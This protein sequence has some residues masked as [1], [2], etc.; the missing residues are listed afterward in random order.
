MKEKYIKLNQAPF[1]NKSVRKAIM[2][3]TQLL[4]KFRKEN[5]FINELAY[6]RQRNFCTTLIKKT[7]RNFYNNLNVNKITDNKS[8]W[9]TVKPSFTEKTL[10]D[11]KIVLVE[12]DTT[13]SEE[14]EVAEIFRSYFDGIVDGL[15]I[16]RCEISKEDSDP[17]LN[18]IKTFGKHPSILK[19]K[20]LSSGCR[21]SFENVRLEDVKKVTQELDISK[22]S[23]LLDIPTK[24][25]KQ[26]SDIFSEF[27]FVDSNHS[28]NN[29]TFPEQLKWADVKPVFQKNSRNVKE[30]YRPVSILPNISKIYERSL[31][32]QLYDYFDVIFSRNQCG[33]R[34]GFS[35]VNC[36]LPMI[37]KWRESL[38]QGGAYG[39]LLTDLSKAFDCLP[40][41][42]II[43]KLPVYGVDMPSLKLI[44]T[45]L[46]KRRQR[47]KINDVYSSWSEILF[48]VS[49]GSI[50][51]PL[52][53]NIFICDLFMFLPVDGIAN[54]ADD[55]T[56][57]STGNG[58]HNVMSD[59][60]QASDI[61]SKW[62]IDNYLKANPDKYHVLLSETSETQ[63]IVEN[64]PIASSSSE[65]LLGIKIIV[66][67]G[68]KT[69]PFQ[70]Q[71]P[72]FE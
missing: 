6:K 15:N 4:N 47:I 54:Y 23:Q 31:Y 43:A 56:P 28:I 8:F 29:S 59:L 34:K 60:E 45:Y 33:F 22:A 49:Q 67:R 61:L 58:I 41:E 38:D 26:N 32:T 9:K 63:L 71:R 7:K 30:N 53:F 42:L 21:F 37:E 36:L 19:I 2:V 40:H 18:A 70:K 13:F 11:E 27:F 3:R 25:I 52:L 55:N 50:L 68:V 65:K 44:N 20:E 48:G 35:V 5:S 17:I 69:P 14:N 10:K 24:I 12:N 72:H 39:A 46:S 66:R 1:M 64:V 57:Y 62:F 16:K 51:G